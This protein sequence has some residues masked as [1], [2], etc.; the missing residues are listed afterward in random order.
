MTTDEFKALFL[1]AHRRLYRL[2]YRL[3]GGQQDAE[4]LVQET[5]MRLWKRRN[6]LTDIENAEAFSLTVLKHIYLDTQRRSSLDYADSPPEDYTIPDRSDIA[7]E[8]EIRD[9]SEHVIGLIKH[10]PDQQRQVMM[11]RDVSD[12]SF[13]EISENTG[14]SQGN[15]RTLLSRARKKIREQYSQ[16]LNHERE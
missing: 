14:L 3:T 15:I 7:R 4:D 6:E 1:P 11:M 12:L 13:E 2:A 10:L 9:A 8:V 5:Y 16:L